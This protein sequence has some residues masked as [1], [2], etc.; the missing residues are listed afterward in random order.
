VK[1]TVNQVLP[2]VDDGKIFKVVFRKRTTGELRK[3]ICRT[4]VHKALSGGERAYDP[5]LYNLICVYDIRSR[6]YRSI[7]LDDVVEL[8]FGGE[9]HFFASEE[10]LDVVQ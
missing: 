1:L 8:A 7:C 4:G 6:G 2:K 3:M 9:H 10:H 5:S